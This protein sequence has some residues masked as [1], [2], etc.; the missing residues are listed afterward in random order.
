[1]CFWY[2]TY[3]CFLIKRTENIYVHFLHAENQEHRSQIDQL[4]GFTLKLALTFALR[5]DREALEVTRRSHCHHLRS[6]W[7]G[8]C[9][10]SPGGLT[11]TT[12]G[13]TG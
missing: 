11:A 2:K 9:W 3:L 13:E 12:S 7:I 1:M 5:L 6:D 10:R 4:V 8:R